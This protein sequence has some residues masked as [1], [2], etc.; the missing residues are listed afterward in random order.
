MRTESTNAVRRVHRHLGALHRRH[1]RA[2]GRIVYSAAPADP[3]PGPERGAHRKQ[4]D[5]VEDWEQNVAARMARAALISAKAGRRAQ[6]AGD[7]RRRP[8]CARR[9]QLAVR[10][11]ARHRRPAL[12][13]FGRAGSRLR[14]HRT[15]HALRPGFS[16]LRLD[17]VLVSAEIGVAA[18]TVGSE[19]ASEHRPVIADLW[20]PQ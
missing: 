6:P 11:A 19:T 15:D 3:A 10:T 9:R 1:R 8:E 16:F 7:R 20:L 12:T 5:G 18:C 14:L 13:Q 4:L 2:R 17:H